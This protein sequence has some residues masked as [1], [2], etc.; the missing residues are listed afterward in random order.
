MNFM[1]RMNK[2]ILLE[3]YQ[4]I[5]S[6]IYSIGPY[7]KRIRQLL[8]T[9]KRKHIS[10]SKISISYILAFFKSIAIIGIFTKGQKEF[11]K[12]MIWT[13]FHHPSLFIEGFTY[14]VYGYH[15]RMIYGLTGKNTELNPKVTY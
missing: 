3:G 10:Q 12:F 15:F 6:G 14:V 11:W 9:Y 7:Y 8:R 4:N 2:E 13:I 5:I 1:P